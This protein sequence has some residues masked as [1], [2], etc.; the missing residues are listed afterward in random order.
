MTS[1]TQQRQANGNA[2]A[3]KGVSFGYDPLGDITSIQRYTNIAQA[4][5]PATDAADTTL[6]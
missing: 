5:S 4:P 2:V 6:G 1:E 3:T